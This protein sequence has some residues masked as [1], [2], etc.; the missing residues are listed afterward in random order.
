M[1]I[2]IVRRGETLIIDDATLLVVEDNNGTPVSIAARSSIDRGFIVS[3]IDDDV[4]FNTVLRNLGIDRTVI[5]VP[6]DD[7]LLKPSQ[8]PLVTKLPG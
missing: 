3:C 1:R 5:K 8:L 2:K 7:Q 6:I 4:R